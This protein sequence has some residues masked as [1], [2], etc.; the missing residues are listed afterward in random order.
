MLGEQVR[1]YLLGLFFFTRG[2]FYMAVLD[3]SIE[4]V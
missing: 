4:A 1:C 3:T 2:A